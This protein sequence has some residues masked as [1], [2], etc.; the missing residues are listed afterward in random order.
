[1]DS[2]AMEVCDSLQLVVHIEGALEARVLRSDARRALV[3]V[4]FKGL[5]AAEAE[6]EATSSVAHVGAQGK[7]LDDRESVV[8]LPSADDLD[9]IAQVCSNQHRVGQ[10]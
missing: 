10:A 2:L 3:R 5:D 8:H 9:L 7:V 1:M 6:H 4:A